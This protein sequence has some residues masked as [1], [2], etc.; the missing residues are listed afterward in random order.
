MTDDEGG[1][2][3]TSVPSPQQGPGA[4]RP[5]PSF[6]KGSRPVLASFQWLSIGNKIFCRGWSGWVF[7]CVRW[8]MSAMCSIG[9]WFGRL[10]L[11]KWLLLVCC[12][13]CLGCWLGCAI[14]VGRFQIFLD[15]TLH[16]FFQVMGVWS[17]R[18]RKCFLLACCRLYLG[19][20]LGCAINLYSI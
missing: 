7:S 15:I 11:R 19:C 3:T 17:L 5:S 2:H 4:G 16:I 8:T 9:E 10:E 12:R 14:G 1:G 13:L 18:L 20:W 6:V